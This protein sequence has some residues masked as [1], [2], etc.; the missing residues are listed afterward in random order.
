V[1]RFNLESGNDIC[2]MKGIELA[3]VRYVD[4]FSLK[5]LTIALSIAGGFNCPLGSYGVIVAFVSVL[6]SQRFYF[7]F[8]I[9]FVYELAHLVIQ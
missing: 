5:P 2:V 4:L 7:I 9:L 3:G 1:D 8:R 6:K